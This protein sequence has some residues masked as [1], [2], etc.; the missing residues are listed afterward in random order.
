MLLFHI[1][2]KQIGRLKKEL[3]W[4]MLSNVQNRISKIIR[5]CIEVRQTWKKS[6]L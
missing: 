2:Y 4:E 3:K 6:R 5:T 1:R